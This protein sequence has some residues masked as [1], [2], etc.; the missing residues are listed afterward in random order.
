M[1]G[2]LR[3]AGISP[4]PAH[5]DEHVDGGRTRKV[6]S[7]TAQHGFILFYLDSCFYP[8]A[9]RDTRD[10]KSKL[11]AEGEYCTKRTAVLV[12]TVGSAQF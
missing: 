10:R 3:P 4:I 2:L 5:L 6:Q 7:G 11:P 8:S 9:Q 12:R 1:T